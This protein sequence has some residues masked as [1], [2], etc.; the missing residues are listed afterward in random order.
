MPIRCASAVSEAHSSTWLISRTAASCSRP[1]PSASSLSACFP[2]SA[3]AGRAPDLVPREG[4]MDHEQ[5]S[6]T[7]AQALRRK[8]RKQQKLLRRVEKTAARLER[9]K[10]KLQALEMEISDLERHVAEVVKS[11]VDGRNGTMRQALLIFN[12]WSGKNDENNHATRL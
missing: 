2:S 6:H 12:P 8:Q 11:S 1:W 9:R 7:L 5:P 4:L 3:R 10:L